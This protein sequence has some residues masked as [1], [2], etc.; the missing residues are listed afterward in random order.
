MIEELQKEI[1]T[2]TSKNATLTAQNDEKTRLIRDYS[3]RFKEQSMLKDQDCQR[4]SAL[5]HKMYFYHYI[6]NSFRTK[7]QKSLRKNSYRSI[8]LDISCSFIRVILFKANK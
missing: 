8:D 3:E 5:L 6:V 7:L 1:K 2:L 4:E